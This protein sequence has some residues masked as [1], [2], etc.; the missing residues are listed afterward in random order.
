MKNIKYIIL[1]IILF[2]CDKSSIN[3]NEIPFN[4][5]NNLPIITVDINGKYV[6]LLVDTGSTQNIL[7]INSKQKLGFTTQKTHFSIGGI[8]GN[9]E[10]ETVQ[11]TTV[12]YKGSILKIDFIA[13]DLSN[14]T[15]SI[16]IQGI[17]GSGFLEENGYTIDFVNNKLI[18]KDV[19]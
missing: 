15:A 10:L 11:N 18:I 14:V 8:G 13:I 3:I 16:G 12:K 19:Q 4:Q 2:S 5:Y 1:F 9:R 7:D 17:I 6:K